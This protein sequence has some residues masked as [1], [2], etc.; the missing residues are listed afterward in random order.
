MKK[1]R[2]IMPITLRMANGSDAHQIHQ[3]IVELA[4]FEKSADQVQVTQET[5]AAQLTAES[6][7]FQCIVS[8]DDLHGIVGFAL[9]YYNYSTWTGKQGLHLEDLY[10]RPAY[11]NE[12]I[13]RKMLQFLV[14]KAHAE[15][16]G[17]IEW[18][19]LCWNERAQKFYSSL[20]AKPIDDFAR[21]RLDNQSISQLVMPSSVSNIAVSENASLSVI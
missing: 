1:R 12:K 8:E 14:E 20:G 11:R 2:S 17:R 18:M 7:P 4:E 13:G 15:N 21:W 10:V 19:V 3:L 16:L 5:L 6:P 9:F